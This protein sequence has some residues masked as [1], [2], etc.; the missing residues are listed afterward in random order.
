MDHLVYSGLVPPSFIWVAVWACK[1]CLLPHWNVGSASVMISWEDKC[2]LIIINAHMQ[3]MAFY[4]EIKAHTCIQ[5]A[6][7]QDL[8]ITSQSA[9]STTHNACVSV[10]PKGS[11]VLILS[12]ST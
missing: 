12:T 5:P 2:S 8:L 10:S 11:Y 6:V 3:M 1:S 7:Y 9:C 4:D